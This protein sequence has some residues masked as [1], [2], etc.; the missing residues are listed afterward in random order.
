MQ[1]MNVCEILMQKLSPN[2]RRSSESATVGRACPL[3]H[4]EKTFAK[5]DLIY[6]PYDAKAKVHV[7]KEGIVEIY[8]L[9]RNGRRVIIDILG[10]GAVFANASF[11]LEHIGSN[12]FAKARS[13]VVLCV[14]RKSYFMDLVGRTPVLA[15]RLVEE[16]SAKLYEADNRIR[17]L[18]L[19]D[20]RTRVIGELLRFG[21]KVGKEYDK[22]IIIDTKLTH[23]EVAEMAGVARETV[24]RLWKGLCEDMIVLQGR[25]CIVIDKDRARNW[26]IHTN[27]PS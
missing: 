10:S 7:L 18:I 11:C 6:G 19:L 16:L 20:A 23:L 1:A 17:D 12:D 9:S 21:T 8:Q 3:L 26:L 4:W 24:S 25:N 2:K 22:K 15:A 14:L 5:G 27:G 13:R